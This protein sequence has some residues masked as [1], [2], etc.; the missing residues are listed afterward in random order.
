[1]N[2]STR[3]EQLVS[4]QTLGAGAVE[5]KFKAE[6]EAVLDNIRDP[7]TEAEGKRKIILE[8]VFTPDAARE[9][10]RT[11]ITARSVFAATKP[12]SEIMFIGR[13]NGETVAT[14]VH[15]TPEDPRQGVLPLKAEEA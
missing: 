3:V 7:N 6:L 13:Q 4:L 8:F 10:V 11:A 12:T 15:G 14:V 5:E 2:E 1:M 9:V